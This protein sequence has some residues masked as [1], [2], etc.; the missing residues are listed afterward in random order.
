MIQG[1]LRIPKQASEY[2]AVSER[3]LEGWLRQGLRH[4]KA[5][6]CR[7]TKPEWV[8]SFLSKYEVNHNDVDSIVSEV[9]KNL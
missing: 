5:G 3:T 8:D 6:G 9:L 4:V 1:W 7:L 2:S